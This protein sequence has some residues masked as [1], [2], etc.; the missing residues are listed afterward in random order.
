M[1]YRPEYA[2][3]EIIVNF[4]SEEF[5]TDFARMFGR[6]LGYELIGEVEFLDKCV[7]YRTEKGKEREAIEEFSISSNVVDWASLR[8]IRLESTWNNLEQ[9][10]KN[11][12]ELQDN[13]EI[14]DEEYVKR[15]TQI[16]VSLKKCD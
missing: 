2:E 15:I 9:I 7:I 3:G 13:L 10:V 12:R 16:C 14:S 6:A 5:S 1:D 4:K 11:I 8:D